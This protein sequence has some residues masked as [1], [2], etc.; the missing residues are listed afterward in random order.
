MF[1]HGTEINDAIKKK[2]R[3]FATLVIFSF[4]CLSVRIWYLQILKWQYLTGLSENNR[5][6]MVSLPAYRGTIKDRNGETLVSIRP[7]F[8]LYI[9]PEDA[10]ESDSSLNFLE[11]KINFENKTANM[12]T[13][14]TKFSRI[15][16]CGAVFPK[17]RCCGLIT[18]FP[19]PCASSGGRLPEALFMVFQL[20]SKGANVCKYY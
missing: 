1:R 11:T 5:I 16:E 8:N 3:I 10:R 18:S 12:R 20:D 6:R 19:G 7:S 15:F 9:T 4:I 13:C 2:I 14:L 17:H